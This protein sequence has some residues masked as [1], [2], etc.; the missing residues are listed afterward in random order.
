LTYTH[1]RLENEIQ[2]AIR[3]GIINRRIHMVTPNKRLLALTSAL[4]LGTGQLVSLGIITYSTP[5]HAD[6]AATITVTDAYE[7]VD[8]VDASNGPTGSNNTGTTGGTNQSGGASS[9]TDPNPNKFAKDC[10]EAILDTFLRATAT[11]PKVDFTAAKKMDVLNKTAIPLSTAKQ[12]WAISNPTVPWSSLSPTAQNVFMNEPT[13]IPSPTPAPPMAF[14]FLSQVGAAPSVLADP[15]LY[16]MWQSNVGSYGSYGAT[17]RGLLYSIGLQG[18]A[19]NLT[20][21][22][23]YEFVYLHELAHVASPG[24]THAGHRSESSMFDASGNPLT[25]DGLALMALA[26]ERS[27]TP[28]GS[29]NT[30]L[31]TLAK[32]AK[33]K[34]PTNAHSPLSGC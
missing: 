16:S 19:A 3:M 21:G 29:Y 25:T 2:C 1:V 10:A 24:L 8:P 11:W 30:T 9:A 34:D 18:L 32:S 15:A 6:L 20:E 14:T 27:N 4:V 13:T 23:A 5:A 22:D 31:S 17:Y 12:V 28:N 26:A 7:P 33:I